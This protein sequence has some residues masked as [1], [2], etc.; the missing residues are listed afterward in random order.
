MLIYAQRT[1]LLIFFHFDH[2]MHSQLHVVIG[3]VIVFKIGR[4]LLFF[5]FINWMCDINTH[6][7]P[8]EQ[9]LSCV[10]TRCCQNPRRQTVPAKKQIWRCENVRFLSTIVDV[11]REWNLKLI[12]V[13]R[14]QAALTVLMGA[15]VQRRIAKMLDV[16][17]IYTAQVHL[18]MVPDLRPKGAE[19]SCDSNLIVAALRQK[20]HWPV[21]GLNLGPLDC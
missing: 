20:F 14:M 19:Q 2:W 4:N 10:Q 6:L 17:Q 12:N 7:W 11:I 15:H 8:E 21:D 13:G 5:Y 9:E 1:Y 3:C 18:Q 16:T